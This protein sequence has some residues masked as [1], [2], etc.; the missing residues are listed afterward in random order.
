MDFR[1]LNKAC[2]KDNIPTPFIDHIID[3]YA[4]REVFYFMD[5]F[6]GYTQIQIK[7]ED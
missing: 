3:D 1:D 7:P 4:G 2:L 5:G 6:S